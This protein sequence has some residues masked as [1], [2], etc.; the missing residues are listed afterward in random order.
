MEPSETLLRAAGATP[1]ANGLRELAHGPSVPKPSSA[2]RADGQSS[3]APLSLSAAVLQLVRGA[4][5]QF[6]TVSELGQG[7]EEAATTAGFDIGREHAPGTEV[8]RRL[9]LYA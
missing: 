2:G 7:T 1:A 6:R 5:K 3:E 4:V 8:A 9:D